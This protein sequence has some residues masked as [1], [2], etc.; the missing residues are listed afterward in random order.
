MWYSH[1]SC[2]WG[3]KFTWDCWI[4]PSCGLL[5]FRSYSFC[6]VRYCVDVPSLGSLW[7][8]WLE[9]WQLQ[10]LYE[11]VKVHLKLYTYKTTTIAD[12]LKCVISVFQLTDSVLYNLFSFIQLVWVSTIQW[13]KHSTLSERSNHSWKI[14]IHPKRMEACVKHGYDSSIVGS[15]ISTSFLVVFVFLY[16]SFSCMVHCVLTCFVFKLVY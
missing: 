14:H 2:S 12:A 9:T 5:E 7:H 15:K 16:P 1:V 11:E 8:T 3:S 4:Q 13:A 10:C 6:M